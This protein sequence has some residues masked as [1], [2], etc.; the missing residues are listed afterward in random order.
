L[1]NFA[2]R[3]HTSSARGDY[4][5]AIIFHDDDSV[6]KVGFKFKSRAFICLGLAAADASSIVLF[7]A[8]RVSRFSWASQALHRP[9]LNTP[10]GTFPFFSPLFSPIGFI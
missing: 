3:D 2:D 5:T 6:L 9:F 1:L 8:Q 10:A 7:Q 4:V